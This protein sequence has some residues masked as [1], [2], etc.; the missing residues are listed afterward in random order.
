MENTND[1][2]IDDLA[3]KVMQ[4]TTLESPS[5]GFTNAV[6][7]KITTLD[8]AKNTAITIYKPLLSIKH[9]VIIAASITGIIIY[10]YL[11]EVNVNSGWLNNFNLTSF[12][13]ISLTN[14]LKNITF[15]KTTMYA[16]VLFSGFLFAQI[17]FFK[18]SFNKDRN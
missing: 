13:K 2:H 14:P 8:S 7:S 9:W 3:K 4:H 16:L 11:G 17:S 15:S 6:M 10:S 12:S 18:Q 1:K 5:F